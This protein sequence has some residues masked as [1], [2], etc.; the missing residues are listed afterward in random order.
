MAHA[1]QF[2]NKKGEF[3]RDLKTCDFGLFVFRNKE[4]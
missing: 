2:A 1:R 3:N 4:L